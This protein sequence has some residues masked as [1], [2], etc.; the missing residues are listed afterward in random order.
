VRALI[1][2]LA[3]IG[4]SGSA[5]AETIVVPWS[6][7]SLMTLQVLA[8]TVFTVEARCA[9]EPGCAEDL[10]GPFTPIAHTLAG[11]AG[12]RYGELDEA[13]GPSPRYYRIVELTAAGRGDTSPTFRASS[14][15]RARRRGPAAVTGRD[16]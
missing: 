12:T 7:D 10:A 11:G 8:S 9:S 15:A 4:L 13:S 14:A 2:G 16:R 1:V 6:P 5:R 3:M